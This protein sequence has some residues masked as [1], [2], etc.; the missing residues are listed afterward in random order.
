M[1]PHLRWASEACADGCCSR[2]CSRARSRSPSRPRSCSARCS[3]GCATRAPRAC[4]PP[5]SPPARA[6]RRGWASAARSTREIALSSEAFELSDQTAGRVLVTDVALTPASDSESPPG[7]LADSESGPPPRQ[8]YFAAIAALNRQETVIDVRG[9]DLAIAVP[10]YR[11]GD[12]TGAVVARAPADR[13]RQR[14]QRGA[15]RAAGRGGR[16][17]R[18]SRSRSRSRSPARC[19]AGS[20]ACARPRC[21]SRAEGPDV[22]MPRDTG[23]DE[24]G[25]LARA[26]AR[27]QEELRRQE[28]ARRA[29]VATASHELR[30]PLTMLQGTMELLGGGP[31]EIDPDIPTPS[32]RSPPRGAS[33]GASRRSPRSCSTSRGS[34]PRRR[35]APSRSSS[36][37]SRAPSRPSSACAPASATS[38]IEVVPPNGPC[39]GR[40]DPDAVRPRRADP[41][42]Q[43]AALRPPRRADPR[44]HRRT[45]TRPSRSPTAARASRRRSASGSSSASTA[46][47]PRGSEGGFGL[48]LAIGRELAERMGGTLTLEDRTAAA[49][50]SRSPAA[51]ARPG[52]RAEAAPLPEP[53][54]RLHQD[55]RLAP[56]SAA[57]RRERRVDRRRLRSAGRCVSVLLTTPAERSAHELRPRRVPAVHA[58]KM[59]G[60]DQHEP[61]TR[62]QRVDASA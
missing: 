55:G 32:T 50:A 35:C 49:R 19:C 57:R 54:A 3:S 34:T 4:A 20:A 61:L 60:V 5:C 11:R 38:T 56:D 31:R 25:D 44:D 36:A 13:G 40:G 24:V 52:A 21:G 22:P 27:M 59:I 26:L 8:A 43:R 58:S 2:S 39:W 18:S 51:L 53:L 7:F 30:T 6:S 37:S 14:G 28:A 16:R 45:A 41:D 17:P 15:Q 62:A 48:G 42:R 47:A 10:L 23:H 1:R 33:C 46:A 29:F 12:V 9:D